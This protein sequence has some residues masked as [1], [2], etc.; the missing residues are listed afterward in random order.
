VA[1]LGVVMLT[2][3]GSPGLRDLEVPGL[4]EFARPAGSGR[5]DLGPSPAAH[6][7]PAALSGAVSDPPDSPAATLTDP[8]ATNALGSAPAATPSTTTVS[9]PGRGSTTT[10]PA[11][12]STTPTPSSTVPTPSSTVPEPPGN[13]NGPPTSHPGKP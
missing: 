2:F 8:S 12:S 13:G 11:S 9:R 1:Y 3:V 5:A 10:V 6:D 4:A 7:V